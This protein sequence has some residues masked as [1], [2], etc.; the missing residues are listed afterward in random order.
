MVRKERENLWIK[1]KVI[2]TK[3]GPVPYS[4]VSGVYNA[5]GQPISFQGGRDCDALATKISTI[6]Y[7]M[8]N[9]FFMGELPRVHHMK[10]HSHVI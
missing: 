4:W 3:G 8:D 6:T 7:A 9:E 5:I 1:V 10:F 2:T